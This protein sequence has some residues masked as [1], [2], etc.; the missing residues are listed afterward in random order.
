MA[1]HFQ[2]QVRFS[3]M[4]PSYVFVGESE[5]NGVIERLSRTLKEQIVHGRVFLT[6]DEVGAAVRDFAARHNAEWLVENN[7]Y[8]SLNGARTK[9][10]DARRP[11]AA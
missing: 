5:T 1:N 8:L 7:G 6:I 3:D 9:W 11:R 4:A 10:M 2:N